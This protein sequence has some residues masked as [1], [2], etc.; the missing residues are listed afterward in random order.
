M[1]IWSVLGALLLAIAVGVFSASPFSEGEVAHAQSLPTLATMTLSDITDATPSLMTPTEL[2]T[3]TAGGITTSYTARVQ[4]NFGSTMVTA[5]APSGATVEQ[6]TATGGQSIASGSAITLAVGTT[7]IS[8]PVTQGAQTR[9]Y[10]VR[11]T[12]VPVSASSDT[13]LSSLSLSNVTLSPTFD[14]SKRKYTDR[15]PN[16]T[17]LTTVTARASA[18]A[19]VDIKYVTNA[20]FDTTLLDA[21]DNVASGADTIFYGDDRED[22]DSAGV[23]ELAEGTAADTAG[24]TTIAI[25]VRAADVS[26]VH[27]YTVTVTRVAKNANINSKLA[28]VETTDDD[29]ATNNGLALQTTADTPI[30][31]DLSPAYSPDK[32]AYTASVAYTVRDVM[33]HANPAVAVSPAVGLGTAKVTSNKDDDVDT[34]ENADTA[35]TVDLE[36]GANVITIKVDA[37][38]AIATRTYTVTVTRASATAS[39]DAN[40]SSLSLTD[41]TLSPAFDPG[42]TA[43]TATVRHNTNLTAVTASAA[44]SGAIVRIPMADSSNV[45]ALAGGADDNTAGTTTIAI[46]VTAAD[47]V[48]DKTYTVTVTRVAK[49]ANI[50]SKL[51][52]VETTDDDNATNNGLALQTT[53]DTPITIDLSPAYSPDKTAYTA[54]VAYTVRDVMVHANP[55]V[56]VSPAVGL[57]TAKVTSNKDD[58]VDTDENADTAHTVDLEVG[59]NVIT[60]KVDAANAIATRT[61]TVTVTRA[62]ATASADANLSSLS[63]TDVTLSPAFDPGKTAYTARVSN[64]TDS[65]RVIYTAM[66]DGAT[67]QITLPTPTADTPNTAIK[68]AANNI[69]LGVGANVIDIEVTAAN[70]IVVKTYKV[71][72]D[73][74]AFNA[75]DNARL[76]DD[77]FR[78]ATIA[79]PDSDLVIP[80][81]D[82]DNPDLYLNMPFASTRAD[83]TTTADRNQKDI[84]LVAVPDE[85]GARVMVTSNRD[86]EVKQFDNV[87]GADTPTAYIVEL[88]P[89]INVITIKVTAAD[90]VSMMTYTVTVTRTGSVVSS[91]ATLQALTLSGIT[92]TPAFNPGTTAY[93]AEVRDVVS[94]MVEAMATHP[95]ATVEGTGM[96]TLTVGENVISVTVTAEDGTSQTYTVTVTVMG[97]GTLLDRYDAND[98]NRIDKSEALTAIEDYIFGGTLTKDQALQVITLYIFG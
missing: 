26:S 68:G 15:V 59:A 53:A 89:G 85:S 76:A 93:T 12:R 69:N 52:P 86:D 71:T 48:T 62:S 88:K 95:G 25:R 51:A 47:G 20:S 28:P 56:A 49:N 33:V 55:A 2:D 11:V 36:V 8:I 92:L 3:D 38:N 82:A 46:I 73:R 18:G 64:A 19:E 97:A 61:Y 94:T 42:K 7:T 91:D 90:A 66:G 30:T 84:T 27:Y 13:N 70:A 34:D 44:D 80:P 45:V 40:L 5:T 16:N 87:P 54:S 67:V 22:S 78:L 60:I 58:D 35:H 63:L 79:R 21:D 72:I 81:T 17:S 10:T 39:A 75:S 65:T 77:T 23:V 31:I 32:T 43:Y 24:T 83:Y 41:V 98:N 50:N 74:A 9:T 96:R 37:A 6:I 1:P 4:T 14:S 57:G 29:N